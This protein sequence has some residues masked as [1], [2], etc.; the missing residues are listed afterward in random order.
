MK[1]LKKYARL[2]MPL[3]VIFMGAFLVITKRYYF[4]VSGPMEEGGLVVFGGL[5]FL[6]TGL[7]S[8]V[9][10]VI[11]IAKNEEPI[12]LPETTRGK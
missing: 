12:Q 1:P 3:V 11:S 2:G 4:G 6:V 7:W 5:L 10:T 8:L 9:R